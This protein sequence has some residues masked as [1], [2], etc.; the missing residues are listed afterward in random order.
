MGDGKQQQGDN[1]GVTANISAGKKPY[2]SLNK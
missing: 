1:L 2:K